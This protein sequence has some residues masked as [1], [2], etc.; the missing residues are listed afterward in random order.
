M[1]CRSVLSIIHYSCLVPVPRVYGVPID[2][3]IEE[4]HHSLVDNEVSGHGRLSNDQLG[5]SI[6]DAHDSSGCNSYES[7]GR[8]V[9]LIVVNE[10]SAE[11]DHDGDPVS[12]RVI[13]YRGEVFL[14]LDDVNYPGTIFPYTMEETMS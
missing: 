10:F 7:E 9:T 5:T 12:F 14:P 6:Q 1:S 2:F 8:I 4:V 13:G 11:F 3:A